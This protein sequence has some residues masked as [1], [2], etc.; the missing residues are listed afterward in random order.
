MHTFHWFSIHRYFIHILHHTPN[1]TSTCR[2]YLLP[3]HRLSHT[4]QHASRRHGMS[5]W[6]NFVAQHFCCMLCTL[7]YNFPAFL[8]QAKSLL[9][10]FL[11]DTFN[12]LAF[13]RQLCL[14]F[15]LQAALLLP[16][17]LFTLPPFS[18]VLFTATYRPGF[19]SFPTYTLTACNNNITV[20]T[21]LILSNSFAYQAKLTA[22]WHAAT[23]QRCMLCTEWNAHRIHFV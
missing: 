9:R 15:N 22:T 1:N 13:I 19:S 2:A 20:T 21:F 23:L 18:L 10:Q 7:N 3:V 11:F 16:H 6:H 14:A 8:L 17:T 5:W 4:F 12:K